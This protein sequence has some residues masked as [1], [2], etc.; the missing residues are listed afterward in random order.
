MNKLL[1]Q[2]KWEEVSNLIASI[3]T[4]KATGQPAFITYLAS[5][6]HDRS[7]DH[8]LKLYHRL[9]ELGLSPSSL[10]MNYFLQSAAHFN[11]Y[12]HLIQLLLESTITG[13]P[14][15]L[16]TY[17]KIISQVYFDYEVQFDRKDFIT[18]LYTL[19]ASDHTTEDF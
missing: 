5:V 19:M 3:E 13:T 2:N 17:I 10:A 14:V 16:N 15:D 1:A 18:Y 4:D 11:Q 8:T 7:H 9:A 6:I 12:P